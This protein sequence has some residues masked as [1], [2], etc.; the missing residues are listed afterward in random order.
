[1]QINDA[2]IEISKQLSILKANVETSLK[3]AQFVNFYVIIFV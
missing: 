2:K 3:I 1:M